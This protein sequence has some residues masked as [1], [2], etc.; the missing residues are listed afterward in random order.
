MAERFNGTSPQ[1]RRRYGSDQ[2]GVRA[3][4][5]GA[6][7]LDRVQQSASDKQ[8]ALDMFLQ[9]AKTITETKPSDGLGNQNL[10]AFKHKQEIVD[11]IS[12]YKATLVSGETGSGKSTQVPQF[13]LEAGYDFVIMLVPRRVIANGLHDRLIDELT[14]HIGEEKASQTVGIVHGERTERSLENKILTMTP[15][16]FMRMASQLKD[17]Y[18]EQQVAVIADEIHESNL[19]MDVATAIAARVVDE[20]DDWRLVASSATPNLD[21]LRA[22]MSDLNGGVLPQ[23]SIEGRP[24]NVEMH[25]AADERPAEVYARLGADH[26]KAMIFTSGKKEIDAIIKDARMCLDK[27]SDGGSHRVVFRKLHAE[28]TEAEL[29][30]INDDVADGQRVV[31]VS[32]PVGMSGITIPDVSC[33]ITDG[34]IKRS[35][36]DENSA[37]G[38]RLQYLSRAE[39]MQEF[40]RAGR[41]TSGSVAVLAKPTFV[42]ESRKIARG[43]VVRTEQ[44]PFK[45]FDD[46]DREDF[47]PAEIYQSNLSGVALTST[48]S[49]N[50]FTDLAPF[51]PN[52]VE[53]S[54]IAEAIKVL[55]RLDALDENEEVTSTGR[56]MDQFPVRPELARSLA[57]SMERGRSLRQLGRMALVCAGLSVGGVQEYTKNSEKRWQTLL[58]PTTRDDAIA[59]L[60]IMARGIPREERDLVSFVRT[61]DLNYKRTKQAQK[62]AKKI[63]GVQGIRMLNIDFGTPTRDEEQ[64][65]RTD[66]TSGMIDY[67]YRRM[68]KQGRVQPYANI[69]GERNP[70]ERLI[71]D[72][73]ITKPENEYIAGFPRWYEM[74]IRGKEPKINQILSETFPVDPEDVGRYASERGLLEKHVRGSR[75]N[76]GRAEEIYQEQFGNLYVG[77]EQSGVLHESIPKQ[78]QD[79]LVDYVFRRKG[80]AQKALREVADGVDYYSQ[81]IPSDVYYNHLLVD[82]NETLRHSDIDEMIVQAAQFTRIAHEIDARLADYI[83]R[84]KISIGRYFMEESLA[85]FHTIAPDVIEVNGRTET[86][87]YE[88]GRPYLTVHPSRIEQ[89]V[90]AE[91]FLPGG[92]EVYLRLTTEKDQFIRTSELVHD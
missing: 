10:P 92:Q 39:I 69:L 14:P 2:R 65:L 7:Y 35:E 57:E 67:T 21:T 60:D 50:H 91:L 22:M 4:R 76:D 42:E 58:R 53:P 34:M 61:Y 32:T 54:K 80:F 73:S 16:T 48:T 74:Q 86:L 41:T 77:R 31:I 15:E 72:R 89:Y 64:E 70:T 13:L 18:Q 30:H 6:W 78:S 24:F 40:G 71:S 55:Q 63:L 38:L 26:Q 5:R 49:G 23:I 82:Q 46:S 66:L 3:V 88:N 51:L 1:D 12:N 85:Y 59:Q 79:E 62:T 17:T 25:D 36:L 43:G 75:I 44:L 9:R 33:V 19:Y 68:P 52:Q 11:V 90:G 83:Y 37:E 56:F 28:L 47:G 87:H 27:Q 45:A 84:N 8:K 29:G 20:V 81:R